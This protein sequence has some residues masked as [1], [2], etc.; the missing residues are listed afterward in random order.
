MKAKV[1]LKKIEYWIAETEDGQEIP[2][3]KNVI[4]KHKIKEGDE[5]EGEIEEKS[6]QSKYSDGTWS[7]SY[8]VF[9]TFKIKNK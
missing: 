1:K 8:Q 3:N 4:K 5:I 6:E 7:R 9:Q 2:L